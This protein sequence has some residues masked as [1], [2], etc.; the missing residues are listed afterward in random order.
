MIGVV[1]GI[2]IFLAVFPFIYKRLNKIGYRFIDDMQDNLYKGWWGGW[3]LFLGNQI[4]G[5]GMLF[6]ELIGCLIIIGIISLLV[7]LTNRIF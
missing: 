2:L 1:I 5:V 3:R 6:N 4:E 7:W